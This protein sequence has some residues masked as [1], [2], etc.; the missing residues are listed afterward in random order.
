MIYKWVQPF[1]TDEKKV[2][3]I[4]KQLNINPIIA[5]ILLS[6]EINSKSKIEKYFQSDLK[7]LHDPFLI[8]DMDI[9]VER[10]IK[11]LKKGEHIVIYLSLIHI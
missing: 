2:E 5:H 9:A 11:A 10:I 1:E 4:S 3:T 7:D 6:R 8:P